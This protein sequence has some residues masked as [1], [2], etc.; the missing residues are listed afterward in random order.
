MGGFGSGR[1]QSSEKKKT[2]EQCWF[3]DINEMMRVGLL[4]DKVEM[5][6]KF[7]T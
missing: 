4:E 7:I 3:I 5:L 6:E 2:V 1:S